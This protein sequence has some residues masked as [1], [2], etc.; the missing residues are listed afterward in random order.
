V[1]IEFTHDSGEAMAAV[2]SGRAGTAFLIRAP[3][4]SEVR[5]IC[6]AGEKMPEKTTYF[7]PKLLTG[8]VFRTLEV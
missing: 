3:T 5:A 2:M 6:V 1:P 4:A 7:Y 8:L